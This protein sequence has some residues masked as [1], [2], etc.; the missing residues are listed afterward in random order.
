MYTQNKEKMFTIEI[1]DG[2]SLVEIELKVNLLRMN[3]SILCQI[4]QH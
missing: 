2:R 1:E 4:I 3:K